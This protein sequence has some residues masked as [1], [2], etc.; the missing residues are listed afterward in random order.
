MAIFVGHILLAP[1]G[2]QKRYEQVLFEILQYLKGH[3]EDLRV[4]FDRNYI[5]FSEKSGSYDVVHVPFRVS[6]L[7]TSYFRIYQGTMLDLETKKFG[8]VTWEVLNI[9]KEHFPSKIHLYQEGLEN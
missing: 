7:K 2:N 6:H 5:N 1:I 9:L 8:A 3:E 4:K